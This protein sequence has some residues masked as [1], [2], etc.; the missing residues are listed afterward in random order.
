[1]HIRE[2][3]TREALMSAAAERIAKALQDATSERGEAVAALSGGGTPE[4]AYAELATLKLDWPRVTFALVDERFVPPRDPASNEALLRRT[5]APALA[6][7]A[8][9]LPMYAD[10]ADVEE[11]AARA[12]EFY[13]TQHID[14]ALMG[15][16]GDGH[17]ASWFP[18]S[19][20]LGAALNDQ[21]AVIAVHAP[22]AAGAAERLTLTRSALSKAASVVL[23]ITGDEKRRVLEDRGRARLPIDRLLELPITPEVF[24][25]R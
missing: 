16:G 10:C 18:Q 7:G 1:M 20:Q 4:P 25:A 23:L 11:A 21:R 13:S 24:W 19:P 2:F 3:A 14:I 5:L 8:Q 12:D 9:L 6:A 22:G 15:M 17:T